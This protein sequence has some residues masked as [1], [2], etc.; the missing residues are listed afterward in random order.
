MADTIR[1]GS[2]FVHAEQLQDMLGEL[3]FCRWHILCLV[4]LLGLEEMVKKGAVYIT[5]F[6]SEEVSSSIN[7]TTVC[8]LI[9][10]GVDR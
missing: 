1:V 7:S 6:H 8:N 4:I 10:H 3:R 2:P 9:R 5:Y